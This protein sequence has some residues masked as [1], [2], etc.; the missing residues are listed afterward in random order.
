MNILKKNDIVKFKKHYIDYI[1]NNII[2]LFSKPNGDFDYKILAIWLMM[3][4]NTRG[5]VTGYGSEDEDISK[6][7]KKYVN[8]VRVVFKTPLGSDYAY[9][10]ESNLLVKKKRNNKKLNNRNNR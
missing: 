7:R 10:S 2:E 4:E 8:F 1:K 3:D 6:K 9:F 5:I